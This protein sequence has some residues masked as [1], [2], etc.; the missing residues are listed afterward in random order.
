MRLVYE[1]RDGLQGLG[2]IQDSGNYELRLYVSNMVM[3]GE[4]MQLSNDIQGSGIEL[5]NG[6]VFSSGIIKIRFDD[7]VSEI[8]NVLSKSDIRNRVT[9]WQL[10]GSGVMSTLWKPLMMVAGVIIGIKLLFGGHR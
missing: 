6:L 2:Q 5:P 9:S 4:M 10:F 8:A 7:R 1:G 3:P